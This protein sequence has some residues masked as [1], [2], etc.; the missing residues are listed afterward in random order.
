MTGR[1]LFF[2]EHDGRVFTSRRKLPS[3]IVGFEIFEKLKSL[4]LTCAV[5]RFLL[6]MHRT[7]RQTELPPFMGIIHRSFDLPVS[8]GPISPILFILCYL[9]LP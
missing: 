4:I 3:F 5:D 1:L 2:Y 7:D 9:T 8:A 6:F